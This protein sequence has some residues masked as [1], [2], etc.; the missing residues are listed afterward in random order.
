MQKDA[1]NDHRLLLEIAI[2]T[3][4][5][6]ISQLDAINNLPLYPGENLLWDENV[7]PTLNYTGQDVL[8]LPKLN[9][10]YLTFHDYLLRN[11]NLFRL[12]STYEIRQDVEDATLRLRPR[13][14]MDNT[15]VFTG[16]ARS[17]LPIETFNVVTVANPNLGENRPAHVT[18]EV[19]FDVSNTRD[20]KLRQEWEEFREHDILF[21]LT[22]R[23]KYKVG[24]NPPSTQARSNEDFCLEYIRGCEVIGY[25]DKEGK[26][27]NRNDR[28]SPGLPEGSMRTVRVM[29]DPA[30]YKL[31]VDAKLSGAIDRSVYNTFNVVM[32]R[33]AEENNFKAVLECIRDLMNT[34]I[35]VP[36]WLHDVLLVS[37]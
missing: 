1:F 9:L 17:C 22:I 30:Q 33:R 25:L 2:S 28:T 7:V 31:D 27:W 20:W 23:A 29:L 36:A 15:T 12:E 5:R 11:F 34:D 16:W 19:A 32:K 18:A 24:E 14:G 6:R 37:C 8:A 10:Q 35:V 13:I 21:L 26:V 4:E 3:H